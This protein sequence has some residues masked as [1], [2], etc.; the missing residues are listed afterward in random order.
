MDA[1]GIKGRIE[2]FVDEPGVVI[3]KTVKDFRKNKKFI[4]VIDNP[5][6]AIEKG[7]KKGWEYVIYTGK[8]VKITMTKKKVKEKEKKVKENDDDK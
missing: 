8:E 1:E 3:E 5:G 6:I 7:V 4:E 2:K